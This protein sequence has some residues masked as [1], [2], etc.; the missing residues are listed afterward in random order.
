[1]AVR[2]ASIPSLQEL[3]S[4]CVAEC[5]AHLPGE[6][7]ERAEFTAQLG[8]EMCV[9]P[10]ILRERLVTALAKS[11]TMTPAEFV[12]ISSGGL[13]LLDLSDALTE[14]VDIDIFDL[15]WTAERGVTR[16]RIDGTSLTACMLRMLIYAHVMRPPGIAQLLQLSIGYCEELSDELLESICETFTNLTVLKIPYCSSLSGAGLG[17]ISTASFASTLTELDFSHNIATRTGMESLGSASK[18]CVLTLSQ[19]KDVEDFSP[20]VFTALSR[21]DVCGMSALSSSNICNLVAPSVRNLLELSL[22][23]SGISSSDFRN[24]TADL[25]DPLLLEKIDLSWCE[26][27][28]PESISNFASLCPGLTNLAL[29]STAMNSPHMQ[30]IAINCRKLNVLNLSRCADIDDE[31][32][33]CLADNC[34]LASLDISWAP[35]GSVG[36]LVFLEKATEL[37]VLCLQGCKTVGSDVMERFM[38]VSSVQKTLILRFLDLSWVNICSEEHAKAISRAW[39]GLYV[40]DYYLQCFLDGKTVVDDFY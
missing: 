16:I 35:V 15:V 24:M 2:P 11:G 19:M 20:P 28:S 22:A 33:L 3:A 14:G 4:R 6:S 17:I 29:Q 7:S 9:Y 25:V 30:R 10:T 5:I 31:T 18:L 1:M 27:L 36:L 40:V 38:G 13:D 21:L 8:G 34:S 23:E 26:E 32:L 39:P 12:H 37:I